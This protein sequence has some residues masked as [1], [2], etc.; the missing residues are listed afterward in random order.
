MAAPI[1]IKGRGQGVKSSRK[2]IRPLGADKICGDSQES[3]NSL[4]ASAKNQGLIFLIAKN[5]NLFFS[6]CTYLE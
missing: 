4:P 2:Q 3:N 6:A 1:I 5:C